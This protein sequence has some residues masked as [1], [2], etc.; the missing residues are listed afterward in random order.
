MG[1]QNNNNSPPPRIENEEKLLW[2]D[3]NINNKENKKYQVILRDMNF[4]LLAIEN[5][6]EGISE[7]KKCK[8]EKL[9]ILISASLF[10]NFINLIKIEKERISCTLNIIVFTSKKGKSYLEEICNKDKDISNGLLF[11]KRNIFSN[12]NDIQNFLLSLG[13]NESEKEEIFEKIEKNEQ[14]LPHIYYQQLL[15][16]LTKEE[17]HNF[18]QYLI[19]SYGMEEFIG[20]LED[21]PQMPNEVICKYWIRAYTLDTN[22]NKIM[23]HKLQKKK[24]KFFCPFIKM[25]YEGIENKSL[26]PKYDIVLYKSSMIS[27]YELQRLEKCLNEKN[28]ISFP[29]IFLYFR[30][31]QTF[32]LSRNQA[33]DFM[34][35]ST[36]LKNHI[37]VLFLVQPFK[38]IKLSANILN[39]EIN[40]MANYKLISNAYIRDFSKFP[41]EEK[42]EFFPFSSFEVTKINKN[43]SD[44]V[45]ITLEYLGKYRQNMNVNP[46]KV[47]PLFQACEFGKEIMELGLINYKKKYYWNVDKKIHIK[48]GNVSSVLY[49]EKNLILFSVNNI[50]R[51]HNIQNNE[52]ILDIEA[53]EN[54]IND[55]LKVDNNRFISSSKDNTIKYFKLN[56]D[57]L[58]YKIIETIKIHTDEVNQTIQLK[59]DNYYASCSNDKSICIW[60]FEM[61]EHGNN[62][63][64]LN[65]ILEG[66]E[67]K[68]MSIFQLS[69]SSIISVS[70]AGILK[71]WEKDKCTK[72]LELMEIPLNHGISW[73]Y[74]DLIMIGTN[75]SI[76]FVD[77]IKKEIS[78]IIPLNLIS[79]LFCKFYDN[80]ILGLK[81]NECSFLREFEILKNKKSLEFIAEG[82]DDKALEISYMKILDKRTIIT[83][84]KDQFIKIWKKGPKLIKNNKSENINFSLEKHNNII[85]ESKDLE[86]KEKEKKYNQIKEVEEE[87]E[88][89]IIQLKEKEKILNEKE[90]KL[91]EKE[92][93]IQNDYDKL[94]KDYDELKKEFEKEKNNQ[95]VEENSIVIKIVD[96]EQKVD[97]SLVCHKNDQFIKIEELFYEN[98]HQYSKE[99]N[100][101]TCNGI[102]INRNK[103]LEQNYINNNDIIVF[104]SK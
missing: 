21:V 72:S 44:Y 66:H 25:I 52:N 14:I 65:T 83:F 30:S 103:T 45:E 57:F 93:K 16:P 71:F 36:L 22:F 62:S 20:Q 11:E 76:L 35:K 88:T 24:G 26:T 6:N 7:I 69:D 73:Y 47:L 58:S 19:N 94:K 78:F 104:S 98:Y 15:E 91:N 80:L 37:K 2:I 68:V 32:S 17:I 56:N 38:F 89:R 54:T 49:F 90:I 102:N 60:S 97:L 1:S 82:N 40:K 5:E 101:F 55:L 46:K 64:K 86:L 63:F 13:K 12:I 67:S 48:D 41:N 85:F 33:L 10:K 27:S 29:K 74:D 50:I 79:T 4:K 43:S 3:K 99:N 75:R 39:Q 61:I 51:L 95:L 9:N 87:I 34:N 8:F 81:E 92:I 53:H 23:R 28:E 70:E 31:F 59:M 18:N 42:V 96:K 100:I 77:I 84:D